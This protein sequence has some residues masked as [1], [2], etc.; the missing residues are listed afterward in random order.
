MY[1]TDIERQRDRLYSL[2]G[3]TDCRVCPICNQEWEHIDDCKNCLKI[4]KA[5]EAELDRAIKIFVDF[6]N[7]LDGRNAV[8]MEDEDLVKVDEDLAFI[9]DDPV[10]PYWDRITAIANRQ[11]AK[12]V[13][14]YGRG[15][16]DDTAGINVRL[17]RIEEELVDTL[18][19]LEHLRDGINNNKEV[20]T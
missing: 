19:Y 1:L 15:V 12:G 13:K 11:R 6:H 2:C 18:M 8:S 3:A 4:A 7:K 20:K 9:L 14:E 17:D 5:S 10:N 16:E